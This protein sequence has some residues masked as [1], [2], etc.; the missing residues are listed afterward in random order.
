MS[1]KE[2]SHGHSTV[3]LYYPDKDG[4]ERMHGFD[5]M[6]G[7][8]GAEDADSDG[9]EGKFYLWTEAELRQILSPE[10]AD[11]IITLYNVSPA[12]NF[13]EAASGQSGGANILHVTKASPEVA[14]SLGM[15]CT[16]SDCRV[17]NG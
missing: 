10:E 13:G 4:I 9:E 16:Q 2:S 17:P 7:F 12:G 15:S 8:Y 5:P 1:Y 3:V 6:G 11:L 14:A